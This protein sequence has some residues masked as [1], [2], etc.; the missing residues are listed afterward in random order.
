LPAC[1]LFQHI[2][3]R[4]SFGSA[5]TGTALAVGT[6]AGVLCIVA[7]LLLPGQVGPAFIAL[8]V[9]L[10]GLALQDSWRFAFFACGRGSAAFLNDL[11]WTLLL[12]YLS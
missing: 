1:G 2:G 11:F 12:S 7:G 9:G 5:A 10:P 3:V 4:R 8:G 6:V